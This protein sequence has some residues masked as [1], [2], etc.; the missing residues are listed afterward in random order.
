MTTN[1]KDPQYSIRIGKNIR[2]A[3]LDAGLTLEELAKAVEIEY[4][5]ISKIER[6]RFKKPAKN[7]QKLCKYFDISWNENELSRDLPELAK[8]LETIA[9]GSIKMQQVIIAFVEALEGV[10]AK[11]R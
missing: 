8:R 5:Q 1:Y 9:H 11:E 3:R 7:V 4:T 10:Q 6:G 2:Q